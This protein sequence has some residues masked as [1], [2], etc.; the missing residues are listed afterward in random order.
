MQYLQLAI[1]LGIIALS[2]VDIVSFCIELCSFLYFTGGP[3]LYVICSILVYKCPEFYQY[4]CSVKV[5][6]Q[7]IKYSL[8]DLPKVTTSTMKGMYKTQYLQF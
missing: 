4:A 7:V 2:S 1:Y 8:H 5:Q 3:H 6:S